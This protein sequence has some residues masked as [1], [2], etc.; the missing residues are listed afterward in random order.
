MASPNFAAGAYAA[1]QRIASADPAK[2]IAPTSDATGEGN[3]AQL[4]KNAVGSVAST[5]KTADVQAMQAAGGNADLV[6]VVTA[7]AE[8]EAAMQ[9][10]V[11]V[12]DK[13]ISAYEDIM[14]MAI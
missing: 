12:R 6:Q 9:T 14:R 8:S 3:F 7:V 1:V 5:G 4:L 10:L 11:A 13:V 2:L